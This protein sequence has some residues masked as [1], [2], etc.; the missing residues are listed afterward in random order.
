MAP[1]RQRVAFTLLL[2][3]CAGV[4]GLLAYLLGLAWGYWSALDW[5]RARNTL[6]VTFAGWCLWG[7]KRLEIPMSALRGVR[8]EI[9]PEG[10]QAV[11]IEFQCEHGRPPGRPR[12]LA[13]AFHVRGLNRRKE[14]LD[15]AFRIAHIL[16]RTRYA[17]VRHDVRRLDVELPF[18]RGSRAETTRVPDIETP[19]AYADDASRYGF[20][21]PAEVIPPFQPEQFVVMGDVTPVTEWRP[22]TRVRLFIP[23]MRIRD[24]LTASAIVGALPGGLLGYMLLGPL[25]AE[26]GVSP[27]VAVSQGAAVAIVAMALFLRTWFKE[28]EVILDWTAHEA[29]F[30]RGGRSRTASLRHARRLML[31]G[32]KRRATESTGSKRTRRYWVYWCELKL[33]FTGVSETIAVTEECRDEA[34]APFLLLLP[35][36]S[37]LATALSIPW[38]WEEYRRTVFPGWLRLGR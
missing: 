38:R 30:R 35:M 31:S 11:P 14:G 7:R 10:G 27:W 37:E 26:R 29:V 18:D 17:V 24:A 9:G 6:T 22:A 13:C 5:D 8:L 16:G 2:L 23:A 25:V 33:E 12:P 4:A 3:A 32:R 36:A 28:R 34:D 1:P 21:E 19:A 15:F 20:D